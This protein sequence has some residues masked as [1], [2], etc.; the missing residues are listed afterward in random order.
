MKYVR[1]IL[2]MVFYMQVLCIKI[3][4]KKSIDEW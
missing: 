3:V 4:L 2:Q 1:Y